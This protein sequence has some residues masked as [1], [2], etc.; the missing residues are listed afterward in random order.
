[1][2]PNEA[3]SR[4]ENPMEMKYGGIP[5]VCGKC[6]KKGRTHADGYCPPAPKGVHG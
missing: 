2:L 1:M 3:F 4:K 6:C 5:G